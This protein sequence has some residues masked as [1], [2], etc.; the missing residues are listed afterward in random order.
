MIPPPMMELKVFEENIL[1]MSLNRSNM[2]SALL[3]E[4][5]VAVDNILKKETRLMDGRANIVYDSKK[6]MWSY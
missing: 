1:I 4:S 5:E 2:I 6:S 3:K